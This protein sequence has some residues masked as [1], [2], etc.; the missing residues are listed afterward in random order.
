MHHDSD[1]VPSF[2]LLTNHGQ[3]L[4]A[5]AEKPDVRIR[6]IADRVGITERATQ[7]ILNDLVGAG[8][9]ERT[10]VGR[11]NTYTVDPDKPF[12]HPALHQP[13]GSLLSG[14]VAWK[15]PEEGESPDAPPPP[16]PAADSY[17]GL[18]RLTTLAGWL[19]H[20]PISFVSLVS[21]DTEVITSAVGVPD[22]LLGRELP[23]DQSICQHVVAS[24]DP[25]VIFDALEDPL[26]CNNVAV[27]TYG[28]RAYAAKP[29][30]PAASPR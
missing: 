9:V 10:R 4:L 18:D 12:P 13:V 14:L 8:Y 26:V 16:A 25:L 3:V 21:D 29:S 24:G 7:T 17:D 19:L 23:L 2:F 22:Q 27:T 28:L 15:T 11:R 6:E 20:A 5:V 30:A 1:A